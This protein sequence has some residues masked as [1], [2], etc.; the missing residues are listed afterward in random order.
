MNYCG[1]GGSLVGILAFIRA[2]I[3]IVKIGIPIILI[4]LGM[5]DIGKAVVASDEKEV[6]AA[7]KMLTRRAIY[8]VAIFFVVTIVQLVFGLLAST[9]SNEM[10]NNSEWAKCIGLLS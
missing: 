5:L 4:I 6:K 3:N 7:T 10:D 9:N 2:I 8:A 1:D